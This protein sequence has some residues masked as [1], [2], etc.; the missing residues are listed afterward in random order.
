MK[1][2]VKFFISLGQGLDNNELTADTPEG[3]TVR[4]LI[5]QL[6]QEHTSLNLREAVI[7]SRGRLKTVLMINSKP[8]S[9]DFF[10]SEG[11][12]ITFLPVISGG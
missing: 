9:L 8:A 2:R 5:E 7:D 6:D 10:L 3:V 4:D 11:D 1:A 12:K